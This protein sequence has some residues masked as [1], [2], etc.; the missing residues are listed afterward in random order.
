MRHADAADARVDA[1]VDRDRPAPLR[2][3]ALQDGA[4]RRVDH[5][6]DV[7]RHRLLEV[8]VSERPH[9]E[10]GLADA[11]L[12]QGRRLVQLH[13]REPG[14]GGL[15]LDGARDGDDAQAVAVVLDDGQDRAP[16]H[17]AVDLGH[18][19][20]QVIGPDLDPRIEGRARRTPTGHGGNRDRTRPR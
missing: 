17:A 13:D 11:G 5:R 12:A 3:E 20:A 9:A 7:P 4:D 18:V 1:D 16:A 6:L 8:G 19:V 15:A 10:D 14:D 2:R